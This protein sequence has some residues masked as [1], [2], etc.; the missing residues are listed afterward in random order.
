MKDFILK[1]LHFWL[2]AILL[3]GQTNLLS[4][5]PPDNT[6][7][8]VSL[9]IA[10]TT[11]TFRI[12]IPENGCVSIVSTVP[13]RKTI[14]RLWGPRYMKRGTY[15]LKLPAKRIE[16]RSGF[17]ELFNIEITPDKEFGTRGNGERQFNFPMG[18]DW[19]PSR[20]ELLIADTGN[21]RIVKLSADG[22][23]ISQHGGF[24]IAFGDKSEEREDS[25]DEPF[26]VATGGFSD[27][28]VSDQNNDRICIFDTYQSYRGNLFP[29]ANDRRNRLDRPRGI[30]IDYENNVWI[31]DGRADKVF[32]ITTTGDKLL[33]VGGYGYSMFQ[34]KDPTQI[35]ISI[36][37]EIYVADRGKSRIAVFDRLGSYQREMKDHLKSPAGVAIDPDGMIFV[38]DDRTN[39]LGMYTPRGVRLLY[40]AH[41]SDGSKFRRPSDISVTANKLFL[42]DSGNHR[43]VTFNRKKSGFSV[44]WQAKSAVI[45]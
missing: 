14:D 31:V 32:K 24:G 16:N 6:E 5:N 25:L 21:D 3:I 1:K 10:S 44:P 29:Q 33:E 7:M 19:D 15:Q 12:N 18:L 28:Y 20:K 37:G 27:F 34:L 22:R 11:A 38:C 36:E 4:A 41:A 9:D 42:L 30:K 17:I 2:I 35:D 13:G 8:W 40:I 45:K 39:E 26:D 23:F 43:V